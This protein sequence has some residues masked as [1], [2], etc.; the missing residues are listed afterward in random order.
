MIAG[1]VIRTQNIITNAGRQLLCQ[2]AGIPS[3]N[4]KPSVLYMGFG[5]GGT[6]QNDPLASADPGL[7]AS[8]TSLGVGGY[9]GPNIQTDDD[10]SVSALERPV[11]VTATDWLKQI[12]TPTYPTVSTVEFSCL[13]L[14]TELN[15]FGHSVVPVSEIGLFSSDADPTQ[16]NGTAIGG[17]PGT[18]TTLVA[19]DTFPPYPITPNIS[20]QVRWQWRM[21]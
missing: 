19:Y 17:Y 5:L 11:P 4:P 15:V 18:G 16:H 2:N 1:P 14:D 9:G 8:Y 21:G 10:V 6:R 3:G 20:I 13:F 7:G 12:D